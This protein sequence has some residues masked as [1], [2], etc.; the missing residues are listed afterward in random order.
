MRVRTAP[1]KKGDGFVRGLS[2]ITT[3]GCLAALVLPQTTL[4]R[5]DRST[6]STTK[7]AIETSVTR[8]YRIKPGDE[9]SVYVWGE[10]RLSRDIRVLPDGTISFP[11]VG[12]INALNKLPSDVEAEITAGLKPKYRDTVPQVTVS[13]KNPVGMQFSIVGKVKSPGA[14]TSGRYVNVLEA[15]AL[16][17]GPAEFADMG[18]VVILRKNDTGL[19]AI[20]VRLSDVLKGNPSDNSLAGLPQIESGDTVVVP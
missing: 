1:T 19:S 20:K 2:V 11:L 16:A 3:I 6:R 10:D 4:A 14:F 9:L 12:Q 18:N 17:G 8:P 7:V 5:S 15:L 13:V